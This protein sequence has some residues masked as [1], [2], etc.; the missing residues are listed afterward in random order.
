MNLSLKMNLSFINLYT[1]EKQYVMFSIHT[2]LCTILTLPDT[3]IDSQTV[4]SNS[5]DMGAY[6][7]QVRLLFTDGTCLKNDSNNYGTYLISMH[8]PLAKAHSS[9]PHPGA[10]V[11]V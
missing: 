10:V 11:G 8:L 7:P 4:C 2:H 6:S 9:L 1:F 3:H 5:E